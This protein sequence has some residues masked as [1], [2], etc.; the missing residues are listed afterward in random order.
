MSASKLLTICLLLA[1]CTATGPQRNVSISINPA[2][3]S[4][5]QPV[6]IVVKGLTPGSK[7]TLT[8]KSMD[9]HGFSWVSSAEF[10]ADSEGRIDVDSAQPKHGSYSGVNG[11]GLIWSMQPVEA[12]QPISYFWGSDPMS[13][14]LQ[15]DADGK[16]LSK[17]DFQRGFLH[18]V[19]ST[20]TS[21]AKEGFEGE[22]FRQR[23]LG[24]K[25]SAVFF[26][27]GSAFGGTLTAS[28]LADRGYPTLRV[29]YFGAPGLP[30]SPSYTPLEYFA[31]AL[32]WLQRRSGVDPKRIVVLG[33]Q[34]SSEA[35]LLLGV[36][37]PELVHGVVASN[38]NSVDLCSERCRAGASWTLNGQPLPYTSEYGDPH[39]N[40]VP[41]AVIPVETIRGP[42]MT[43]CGNLDVVWPSCEFASAIQN[44]LTQFRNRYVHVS[45]RYDQAG[46]QIG[47]LLPY[48]PSSFCCDR[49]LI[50]DEL[51]RAD[52]WPK[53]LNFLAS[54]PG[55]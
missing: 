27:G 17:R 40:D 10:V 43:V 53:L 26:I 7:A 1:S 28:D 50:P 8:L 51:G 54:I 47:A 25:H 38:P 36:H 46:S 32:R 39:P 23:S 13:F 14:S 16:S 19:T 34:K 30:D 24:T 11:M 4:M 20:Y 6:H 2:V 42:I 3:T 33:I 55:N 22:F 9:S 49:T 18:D 31:K 5:D 12:S 44:R 37:F 41:A 21:I 15:V 48:E 29:T 52:V 45:Y 35:A